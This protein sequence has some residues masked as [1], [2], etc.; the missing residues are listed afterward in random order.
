MIQSA[1][2]VHRRQMAQMSC[3]HVNYTGRENTSVSLVSST[4]VYCIC[5]RSKEDW[6]ED[7]R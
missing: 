5:R 7:F 4:T 3:V 1:V 6:F 2:T